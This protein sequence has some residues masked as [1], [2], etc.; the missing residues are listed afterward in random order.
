MLYVV[1]QAEPPTFF[2]SGDERVSESVAAFL[3]KRSPGWASRHL[4]SRFDLVPEPAESIVV[5]GGAFCV[6]E[7]DRK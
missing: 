1:R 5:N 3:E 7:V 2:I 6:D 4:L